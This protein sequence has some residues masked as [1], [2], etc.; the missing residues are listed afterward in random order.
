MKY[1]SY[2]EPDGDSDWTATRVIMSADE[3][4]GDYWDFWSSKMKEFGKS[5]KISHQNCI[6]DWC[7]VHWATP[8]ATYKFKDEFGYKDKVFVV[9]IFSEVDPTMDRVTLACVNDH[10]VIIEG[11]VSINKHLEMLNV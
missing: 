11:Y 10:S 3:I 2:V 1:Y 9:D 4:L 8:E 5:D 7:T 6:D